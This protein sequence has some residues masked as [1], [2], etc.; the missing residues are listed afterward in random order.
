MK[1]DIYTNKRAK[2]ND[3]KMD[4]PCN[5]CNDYVNQ[6]V[7]ISHC[8]S[9]F[10]KTHVQICKNCLG[11]MIEALDENM[12]NNFKSDYQQIYFMWEYSNKDG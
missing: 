8:H 6:V 5:F 10:T 12:I 1:Y 4:H 3:F 2:L 7:R 11:R 9:S